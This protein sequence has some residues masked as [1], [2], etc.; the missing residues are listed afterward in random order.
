[1]TQEELKAEQAALERAIEWRQRQIDQERT[2]QW[3]KERDEARRAPDPVVTKSP[4]RVAT[5]PQPPPSRS[6]P[7]TKAETALLTAAMGAIAEVMNEERQKA[8]ES[9]RLMREEMQ[10]FVRREIDKASQRQRSER[11]QDRLDLER[12]FRVADRQ[13]HQAADSLRVN[14]MIEINPNDVN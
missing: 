8:G 3:C 7:F 13:R 11:L 10:E 1:M 14:E 6:E 5:S 2:L 4:H 9:Q 12:S